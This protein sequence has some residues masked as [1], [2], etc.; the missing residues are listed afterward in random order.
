MGTA[1]QSV[2]GALGDDRVREEGIPV[3]GGAI[4]GHYQGT[5]IVTPIDELIEVFCL[6]LAK[7]LHGEIIQDQ[8][9]RLKIVLDSPLP[10]IISSA[11]PQIG[12]ETTGFDKEDI[13]A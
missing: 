5:G 12:E 8:Q 3:L 7:L 13:V 11:S 9:V 6:G 1:D 4:S 10:G 2:E